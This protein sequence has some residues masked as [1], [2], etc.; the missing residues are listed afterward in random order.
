VYVIARGTSPSQA[1]LTRLE[2]MRTQWEPFF[3][4][5]TDNRMTVTTTLR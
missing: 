2:R 4:R 5:I 3:R 1:D